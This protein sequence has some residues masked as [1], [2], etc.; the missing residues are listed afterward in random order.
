MC[1]SALIY[2]KII[3]HQNGLFFVGVVFKKN[4]CDYLILNQKQEIEGVGRKFVQVMGQNCRRL[5]INFLCDDFPML[6][7]SRS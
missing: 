7:K 1:F 6:D 3:A 2:L 5:P 4:E